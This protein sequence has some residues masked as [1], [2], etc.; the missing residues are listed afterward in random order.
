MTHAA[1]AAAAFTA[2]GTTDTA[3]RTATAAT[4]VPKRFSGKYRAN[5]NAASARHTISAAG[6]RTTAG[7]ATR[8]A[9]AASATAKTRPI[10]RDICTSAATVPK[11]GSAW[12]TGNGEILPAAVQTIFC[13]NIIINADRSGSASRRAD[14]KLIRPTPKPAR[15]AARRGN[16]E[17]RSITAL[18]SLSENP[19]IFRPVD[20]SRADCDFIIAWHYGNIMSFNNRTSA[21]ASAEARCAPAAANGKHIYHS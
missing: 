21:A 13:F 12:R 19:I 6:N 2:F 14:I 8:T 10:M 3:I 1:P 9:G 15:A 20:S 7:I 18:T 17:R 4:T 5:T 11:T 16:A